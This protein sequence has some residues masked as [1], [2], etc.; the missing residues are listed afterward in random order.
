MVET[1]ELFHSIQQLARQLTKSLNNALQPFDIFSSEWT[2]LYVLKRKGPLTQKEIAEYLSIEA[3]PVTRTIKK[4]VE[5]N[6]CL[7][8]KG[9]DKRSNQVVLTEMA[10]MEFPKWEKAVLQANQQL[11]QKIPSE[12]VEQLNSIIIDWSKSLLLEEE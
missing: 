10:H 5:K 12:N 1:H 11:I 4:L 3:P 2:I 6:Y 7:Q 8:V 9:D